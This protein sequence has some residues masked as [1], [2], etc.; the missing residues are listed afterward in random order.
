M[1]IYVYMCV[2]EMEKSSFGEKGEISKEG[3]RYYN[4]YEIHPSTSSYSA[5]MYESE[6]PPVYDHVASTNPESGFTN[7]TYDTFRPDSIY[8]TSV[9]G[10]S[11]PLYQTT[12]VQGHIELDGI[13]Q[14]LNLTGDGAVV[15]PIH[16]TGTKMDKEHPQDI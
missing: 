11:N 14:E 9:E 15:S 16:P 6:L 3:L 8:E 7:P 2:E 4:P 5:Q 1:I 10:I 13:Y 12:T